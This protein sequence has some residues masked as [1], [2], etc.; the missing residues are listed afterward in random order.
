MSDFDFDSSVED[1]WRSF[2]TGLAERLAHMTAGDEHTVA[3]SSEFPE[4]PHGA[5]TFTVTR[6]HRVRATV[7]VA[8]LHT[9][10][11]YKLEQLDAMIDGRWRLLRDNRLIYEV[12]RRRVDE[13]AQVAVDTLRRVWEVVHPAFL[14]GPGSSPREAVLAIG[15]I[16]ETQRQL[17]RLVVRTLE[18]IAGQNITVD[19]DGDI[20]LP[21]GSTPSWLRVVPDEATVEFFGTVVDRVP[22]LTTAAEFAA[23]ESPRWPGITLVLHQ[24][25]LMAF[26]TIEMTA[27]HRENLVAGLGRW[28]QFMHDGAPEIISAIRGSEPP[29]SPDPESDVLPDPLQT[30]IVLDEDGT[31]LDAHEVA[32]I[33]RYDQSAILGYIR[34]AQEQYLEWSSSADVSEA[35]GNADEAAACRHEE[36]AWRATTEQLRAALRVV[37]LRGGNNVSDRHVYPAAP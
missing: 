2:R 1:A 6:A 28:L 21:T 36:K 13:L 8:D 23:T 17:G 12:S 31:T 27:F 19:D 9:T 34:T 10:P 15:T 7:G 24:T 37:V 5:I 20:P 35:S 33:C 30:L 18:G 22:N 11:E 4:G 25:T 3:Q 26:Q 29:Q 14:A 32:E 16:P